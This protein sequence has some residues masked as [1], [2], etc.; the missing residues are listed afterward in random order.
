MADAEEIHRF[1]IHASWRG[2]A[3]GHGSVAKQNFP[4]VP[5]AGATVLGGAGTGANPE[6]L[7]L[8]ALGA[9]FVNTWAIFVKKLNL[10]HPELSLQVSGELGKDPAGGYRFERAVIRPAVPRALLAANRAGVEKSLSLAEKYCILS[11]V[12]RASMELRV[13]IEET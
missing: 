11:K 3:M 8:A 13:E 10:D 4:S 7:L 6:E 9:C 2:D 5:I 12:V 1:S